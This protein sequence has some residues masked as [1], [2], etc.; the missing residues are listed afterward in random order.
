M[1]YSMGHALV[2]VPDGRREGLR[3]H[4]ARCSSSGDGTPRCSTPCHCTIYL[5]EL[6][7]ARMVFRHSGWAM[8][9]IAP[10]VGLR[11]GRSVSPMKF[12]SPMEEVF[13]AMKPQ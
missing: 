6:R 7:S 5:R 12:R 1:M 3:L 13:E 9:G 4:Q 11:Q 10:S 8:E 2:S